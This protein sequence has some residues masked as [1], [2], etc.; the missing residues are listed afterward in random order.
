MKT[1]Y[2]NDF[3]TYSLFLD[4]VYVYYKSKLTITREAARVIVYDRL[5]FQNDTSYPVL[6]DITD[7]Y[8]IT[9]GARTYFALQGSL[10]TQAIAIVCKT[11]AKQFMA[12]YFIRVEN[13]VIETRLFSNESLALDFLEHFKKNVL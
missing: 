5:L 6:C 11:T 3:A 7:V 10:L 8:Y 12:E 9:Q 2:E 1:Y 13:P 4:I